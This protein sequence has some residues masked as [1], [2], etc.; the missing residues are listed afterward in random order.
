[1]NRWWDYRVPDLI[2]PGTYGWSP[3]QSN[4]TGTWALTPECVDR[5]NLPGDER[6]EM[7]AVGPQYAMDANYNRT[8]TPIYVYKA[9]PFLPF[10]RVGQL[11]FKKDFEW[12]DITTFDVGSDDVTENLMK[13]ARL[14]KYVTRQSDDTFWKGFQFNDVPVFRYAD[15]LL[16]KAECILRGATPTMGHS[17]ASLMNEVRDCSSAPH[18]T[19]T[20]TLQDLLD[21]R[22]REFIQEP[23]RRNDLIR[24]GKFENC[25]AWKVAASPATMADKTRRLYPIPTGE[26]NTNTN[27]H[28]N[29]GY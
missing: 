28:Q 17:A 16:T 2:S 14:Y 18:V 25:A 13:G 10:N 11:D 29:P 20:P 9:K 26:M 1:M 23:W 12:E 27:W 4:L 24:Y 5:F 3:T 15:I 19:G 6:N 22:S 21:E 7:I 8:T